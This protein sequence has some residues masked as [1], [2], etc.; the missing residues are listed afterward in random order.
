M[1]YDG[2][3]LSGTI[4][5]SSCR[6]LLRLQHPVLGLPGHESWLDPPE[7]ELELLDPPELLP[8]PPM[9][10]ARSCPHSI[11]LFFFVYGRTWPHP[12]CSITF[13][14]RNHERW[15]LIDWWLHC[16]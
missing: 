3:R 9:P 12:F 5:F 11:Y 8:P 1:R 2:T 16:V 10:S 15:N 7:P 6:S 13:S 4:S 14:G